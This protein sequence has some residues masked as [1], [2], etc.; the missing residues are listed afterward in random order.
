MVCFL[1][2][3]HVGGM[4][5]VYDHRSICVVDPVKMLGL[6]MSVPWPLWTNWF[7]KRSPHTHTH[8]ARRL[9]TVQS[10]DTGILMF[11]GLLP[12]PIQAVPETYCSLSMFSLSNLHIPGCFLDWIGISRVH[13]IYTYSLPANIHKCMHSCYLN[14]FAYTYSHNIIT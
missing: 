14:A 4:G 12:S 6:L 5:S 13:L 3:F 11:F 10:F 7:A 8:I 9:Y 2:V 1:A